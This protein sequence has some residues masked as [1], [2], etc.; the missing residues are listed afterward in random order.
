MGSA[1]M[2][3]YNIAL[4]LLHLSEQEP[5]ERARRE[6]LARQHLQ[7]AMQENPNCDHARELLASLEAPAPAQGTVQIRFVDPGL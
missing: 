5:A 2:A 1:A 3:H 7:R 6:A 4:M